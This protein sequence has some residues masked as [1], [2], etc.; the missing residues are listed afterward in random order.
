[1]Q[2]IS[3]ILVP[4]DFSKASIKILQYACFVGKQFNA[5][6]QILYVVEGLDKY[7]SISIPHISFTELEKELLQSSETKMEV[8][9]EEN[10]DQSISHESKVLVGDIAENIK[11]VAAE[12]E[13]DLIIMGTQG[14]RG[15]EKALFG[16]VAEVVVKTAPCPVLSINPNKR[17]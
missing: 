12:T 16:S 11:S 10:M 4:V 5:T 13:T 3:K 6:L 9:L 17:I 7:S 1:M 15:L 14:Y 8:F 2:K